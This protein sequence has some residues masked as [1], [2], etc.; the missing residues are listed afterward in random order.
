MRLWPLLL[1]ALLPLAGAHP[2]HLNGNSLQHIT[3]ET[4]T[5]EPGETLTYPLD[6]QGQPFTGGWDWLLRADVDGRLQFSL[7][8]GAIAVGQWDWA[9]GEHIGL[10]TIPFNGTMELAVHNP[11]ARAATTSF[12]YD[13]TCNCLFKLVPMDSGPVWLNIPAEAGKQVTFNLTFFTQPLAQG[14]EPDHIDVSVRHVE[15]RP[16]GLAVIEEWSDAFT[17][18]EAPCHPGAKW[19]ACMEVS[20]IARATGDQVLWLEI[21][22]DSDDAWGIG[23]RPLADVREPVKESP[24]P[25]LPLLLLGLVALAQR[26]AT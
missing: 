5:V 16:E 3:L 11:G 14:D 18:R 10:A 20:F 2:D 24:G 26:R 17:V 21:E 25:A 4:V 1:L 23:V 19:S 12:Y 15:L 22:H 9:S 8:M 13:Q 6:F 7:N